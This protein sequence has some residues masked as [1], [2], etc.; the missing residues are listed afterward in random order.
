MRTSYGEFD[1]LFFEE[2]YIMR[3]RRTTG[4]EPANNG[5]TTHC[6]NHLATPA[7][8]PSFYHIPRNKLFL[9]NLQYFEEHLPIEVQVN[10]NAMLVSLLHL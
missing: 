3:E 7:I 5:T 9:K 8:Y 4:F 6:R 2:K 1:F 10:W